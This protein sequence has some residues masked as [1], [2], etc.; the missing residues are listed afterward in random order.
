MHFKIIYNLSLIKVKTL[1]KIMINNSSQFGVNTVIMQID[2]N[3]LR[4][5]SKSNMISLFFY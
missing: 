3:T 1:K 4:Q 5:L 2:I